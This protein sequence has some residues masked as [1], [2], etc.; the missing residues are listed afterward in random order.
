MSKVKKL[1]R[2][3][4]TILGIKAP[5]VPELPSPTVPAPPAPTANVDTGANIS[6]GTSADIKNQRI[7]GR[8]SKGSSSRV[9]DILGGLGRGG[10]SI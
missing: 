2:A 9:A 5:K 10:L 1:M 8:S 3:V 4:Q 6:I 7:S